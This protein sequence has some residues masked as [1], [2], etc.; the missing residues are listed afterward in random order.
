M[1]KCFF[2][3]KDGSDTFERSFGLAYFDEE[4]GEPLI[5][6]TR[7]IAQQLQR[8]AAYRG[9][10][11]VAMEQN[12]R[13]IVRVPV[14]RQTER[15]ISKPAKRGKSNSWLPDLASSSFHTPPVC[16]APYIGTKKRSLL[17]VRPLETQKRR[18]RKWR[19]STAC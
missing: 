15:K 19:R 8:Y 14:T 10:F 5:E 17:W 4:S 12:G 2:S 16:P 3:L 9:C 7:A 13:E 6:H 11:V 1:P 18:G